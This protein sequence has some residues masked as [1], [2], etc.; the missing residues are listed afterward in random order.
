MRVCERGAAR[1]PLAR[2][3]RVRV[4]VGGIRGAAWATARGR[5]CEHGG[6]GRGFGGE[7]R[8]A[9]AM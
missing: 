9:G 4:V 1:S 8:A 2:A 7:S 5:V 6:R 3:D